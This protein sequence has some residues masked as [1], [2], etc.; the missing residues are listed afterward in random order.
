MEVEVLSDYSHTPLNTSKPSIRLL[1]LQRD[2]QGSITGTLEAFSLDDPICPPFRTLSYV[3]GPKVYS[4]SI[5]INT[6]WFPVL[7]SVHPI[8]ETISSDEN[9][10][11]GWWWIDSIC[12][13]QNAGPIAEMERNVQVAMMRRIYETADK[14]I[15]WLGPGDDEG[16][17]AMRFLKVLTNHKKRLD[18]LYRRRL[19]GEKG[20]KVED[21]GKDLSDRSKWA[22]LESL[23]L[24]PWW[25]RVWSLQEYI[26]PRKFVFHCGKEKISRKKLTQA[27]SAISQCRRIDET[28]LAHTAFQAPWIRG[29]VL[30]WYRKGLPIKLIG[31][32][33]YISDYQASDPRDRIYSVLGLAADRFLADPPRYQDSVVEVYSSLVKSFIERHQSLDI[34]CF[35]DRFHGLGHSNI[36]PALPS[37]VPDWRVDVQPWMVPAMAAQSGAG[38]V[39]NFRPTHLQG[40]NHDTFT[41][42]KSKTPL[43]YSFSADLQQLN[44]QGVFM[45][46][47]DGIG[48]LRLVHGDENNEK[49]GVIKVYQCVN[50]T[51]IRKIFET[52]TVDSDSSPQDE[53]TSEKASKYMDHIFR[54]LMLNRRERYLSWDLPAMEHSYKDFQTFCLAAMKTP[55]D[56]HP[57][58]LDW[59]ER[60]RH[61]RIGSHTLEQLCKAAQS[62][63]P[64]LST[65]IDLMDIS[66]HERGFLS[67]FRD[68]TKWMARRLMTTNTE[69]IGM[70]PCRVQKGDQ[71]WILLGCSIPLILRK[72]EDREGFQ[73]IGECYLHGYMGGEVHG[74]VMNGERKVVE[75]CLL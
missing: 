70:G 15:G 75:I 36:L 24:R 64:K 40:K 22:A 4:D 74:E 43:K 44:C 71:V 9:L 8:L 32:M 50:T 72:W 30:R 31:L 35:V 66:T 3:W 13:N 42:G 47:V 27:M 18:L 41:A 51:A 58:F 34:I 52:S 2:K 61:L 5:L 38:Y 19:A 55:F 23:L 53:L 20:L 68:T 67:R 6:R 48:G 21:L 56:V 12:I 29:R 1:N 57:L 54:C 59:F 26:V 73:V 63:E 25:T 16:E 39:G 65:N 28:L 60:N 69:Y 37:W 17:R 46:L 7:R 11:Q 14:T 49:E 62:P 33:G 45:D 10:R